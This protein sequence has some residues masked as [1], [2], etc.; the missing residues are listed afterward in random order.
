MRMGECRYEACANRGL[1]NDEGVCR[2]CGTIVAAAEDKIANGAL[3]RL[4]VREVVSIGGPTRQTEMICVVCDRPISEEE[5]W[6]YPRHH[7][8]RTGVRADLHFHSI[9][10]EIWAERATVAD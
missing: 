2:Q 3:P 9:C 1:M 10:H 5:H 4:P 8:H 6:V 7:N